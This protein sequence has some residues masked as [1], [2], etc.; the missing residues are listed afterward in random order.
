[1]TS[2][3]SLFEQIELKIV[4]FLQI[5]W[6]FSVNNILILKKS[7]FRCIT[8]IFQCFQL[9]DDGSGRHRFSFSSMGQ[10]GPIYSDWIHLV[11]QIF[12]HRYVVLLARLC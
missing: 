9:N 7:R 10:D 3:I 6:F 1:M 8:K 4:F 2:H 12:Y 11:L 5:H